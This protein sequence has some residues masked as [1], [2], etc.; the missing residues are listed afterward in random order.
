MSPVL[1]EL[2]IIGRH[3]IKK[4]TILIDDRRQVGTADFDFVTEEQIRDAMRKI[5]PAY[6]FS[7]ETGSNAN[8]MFKNDVIVA[9]P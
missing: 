4:H 6:R 8:P 9:T 1:K 3:P 7:Y 2:A 5:N